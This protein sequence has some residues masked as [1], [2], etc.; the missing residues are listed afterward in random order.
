MSGCLYRHCPSKF[1][2][3][4]F[5]SKLLHIQ[6][7]VH[8]F[9]N[10]HGVWYFIR[11]RESSRSLCLVDRL[12]FDFLSRLG[13]TAVDD[14]IVLSAVDDAI[15]LSIP[16]TNCNTCHR[17]SGKVGYGSLSE[18]LRPRRIHQKLLSRSR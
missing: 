8:T 12:T 2:I 10:D 5:S 13:R 15:V 18:Q 16:S 7:G 9:P 11:F 17:G 1:C 4:L 3:T 14:A 6:S